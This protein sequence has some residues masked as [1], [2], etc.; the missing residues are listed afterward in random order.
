MSAWLL[1]YA[2]IRYLVRAA[3]KLPHPHP[4]SWVWNI[5]PET[6]SYDRAVLRPGDYDEATRIG[7][8]L[9]DE[10]IASVRARYPSK[11]CE[12][13]EFVYNPSFVGLPKATD[14]VQVLKAL[15]CYEYQSCEHAGWRSSEARAF[16]RFLRKAA[17]GALPGYDEAEWA[18]DDDVDPTG[19]V[20]AIEEGDGNTWYVPEEDRT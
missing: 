1:D 12:D 11:P 3:M 15:D 16:V 18:I 6:G 9:V 2:H 4:L 13:R 7:Q 19:A 20:A 5:D 14:P 8:V 10:N 17:I